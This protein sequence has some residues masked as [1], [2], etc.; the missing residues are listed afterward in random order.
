MLHVLEHGITR[1]VLSI[2]IESELFERQVKTKKINNFKRA[3][4]E[5]QTDFANYLLNDPNIFDFVQAKD[6]LLT[7]NTPCFPP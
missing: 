4:P 3:R 7:I 1:N 6:P 2:Q 5:P